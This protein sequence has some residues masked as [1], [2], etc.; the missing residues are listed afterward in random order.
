ML[1]TTLLNLRHIAMPVIDSANIIHMNAN[2]GC[3]F[4][5]FYGRIALV[6]GTDVLDEWVGIQRVDPNSCSAFLR[7]NL[8]AQNT[9]Y[10]NQDR[11]VRM[12]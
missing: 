3:I 8:C 11:N 2:I 6:I 4:N 9:R 7:S 10:Q 1:L 12:G 5:T